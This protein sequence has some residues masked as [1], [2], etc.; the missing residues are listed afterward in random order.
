MKIQI[1]GLGIVGTA[2]ACLSQKLGHDVIG[3]DIR[4]I[5]SSYCKVNDNI[6]KD[7]DIIFICTPESVV[8]NVIRSLVDIDYNGIIAVRSTVP[9]GTIKYLSEKFDVHI[10]HNPEFLREEYYLEDIMN[11]N[12]VIIGECCQIHGDLLE[13]FYRPINKPII[14]VDTVLSELVKLANNA[15]LSIL[16]TFWNEI[17]ELCHRLNMNTEKI[18]DIILHD[19]RISSYGCEFFGLPYGGKCLPKDIKHLIDCFHSQ[20]L[21]PKLFDACENFNNRLIEKKIMKNIKNI[22]KNNEKHQEYNEK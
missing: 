17:D 16:I 12:V 10:C 15:H 18:S 6:V 1:I 5:S 7:T 21:N 22:M 13:S 4:H 20:G 14:R 9:I 11:P 19:P 3:Y 2:Q 8:E